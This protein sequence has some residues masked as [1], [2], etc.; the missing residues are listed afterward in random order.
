[1]RLLWL[2][3]ALA[4]LYLFF[5]LLPSYVCIRAVFGRTKAPPLCQV[6]PGMPSYPAWCEAKAQLAAQPWQ[7]IS[8]TGADGTVLRGRLL[9]RG[10]ART[11]LFL[12]GFRASPLNNFALQGCFLLEQGFNLLLIDQRAHGE[13]GGRC[14]TLGVLEQ[15]DLLAWLAWLKESPGGRQV[16]VYGLSMGASA[17]AYASDRLDAGQVRCLVLD[18]GFLS[19]ERQI[20]RDCKKR[21]LPWSLMRGTSLL[22]A[23]R[24]LCADL[25][26]NCAEALKNTAIPA[27]FLHGDEDLTVPYAEGEAA[28]AACAAEKEWLLIPGAGH[29]LAWLYGRPAAEAALRRMIEKFF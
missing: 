14:S 25:T 28:F 5:L 2:I 13:S 22:L 18:C 15:E 8:V 21:H 9:D 3:P 10:Y 4:G 12:H 1:M 11:A 26:N 7:S 16:L 27:L 24:I 17:A 29:A 6:K 19:P 20:A 23:R